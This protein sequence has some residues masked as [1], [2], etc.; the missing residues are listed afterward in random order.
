MTLSLPGFADP[1]LGA[2]SCFRAVLEAL[3]R[4]GRICE[5]GVGL[6]PPAPLSSAA[7][8]VL[9]TLTDADTPLWLEPAAEP[10]WEWLAFHAGAPRAAA[11]GDAAFV[12]TSTLPDLADLNAGTH[13]GPEES[14]TLVL[15]LPAVGRGRNYVLR[16]PGLPAPA[17][18]AADGLPDDFVA[19]WA[20]NHALF[21]RGVDVILCAG[22]MLAALP[23]SVAVVEG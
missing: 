13:D 12:Y 14:A 22:T 15:E 7:A 17:R 4:P 19:R 18:F 3:S 1:V 20:A 5:A 9:L 6:T 2:Q 10:A 23:R 21:P 8:A 16:G 11:L